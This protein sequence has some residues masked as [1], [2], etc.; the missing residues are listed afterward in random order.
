MSKTVL[1]SV[2]AGGVQNSR[3]RVLRLLRLVDRRGRQDLVSKGRGD[4]GVHGA[5]ANVRTN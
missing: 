4:I 3:C 5:G 1:I 2:E